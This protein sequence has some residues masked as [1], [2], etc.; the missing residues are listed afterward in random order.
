MNN[1]INIKNRRARFE[2]ILLDQYTAGIVLTG[3]EIKSIRLGKASLQEAYCYFHRNEL[4]IKGMY[5]A[6]YTQGNIHNDVETRER[7]LLLQRK[8][9]NKLFRSKEKG[10]TIIPLQLFVNEKGLAK[11]QVALAKGKKLHDKRQAIKERDVE[12]ALR[13][14]Q[15]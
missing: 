3:P 5:V 14:G 10:M 6:P 13:R 15:L 7:K 9:L 11:L 4:W 2:Y 12:R 1:H 8:E